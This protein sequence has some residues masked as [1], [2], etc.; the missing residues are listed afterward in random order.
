MIAV[1]RLDG[2]PLVVNADLIE[3]IE[4]TPD[5]VLSLANGR[6]LI[7]RDAPDE[8]VQRVIE[9]K[10]AVWIGTSRREDRKTVTDEGPL[11]WRR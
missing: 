9:F 10:R 1:T 11:A 2:T 4:Q 7:V 3:T 5:T 6:K 8:L